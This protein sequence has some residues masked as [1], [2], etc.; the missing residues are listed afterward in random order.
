MDTEDSDDRNVEEI[1]FQTIGILPDEESLLKL[2]SIDLENRLVSHSSVLE[3]AVIG[4]KHPKW[5][6]RPLAL[7]KLRPEIESLEKQELSDF[8]VKKFPKWQIPDD[9]LFINEIPKT[10]VGKLNKKIIREKYKDYYL[11]NKK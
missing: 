11:A 8:L 6:E 1:L 5:D 4:I 7:I 9:F 2:C 3:A 10:S